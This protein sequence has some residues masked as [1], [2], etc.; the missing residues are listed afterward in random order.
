VS[1]G[2]L[3]PLLFVLLAQGVTQEKPYEERVFVERVVVNVHVVDNLGS[4]LVFRK[5]SG[6]PGR[7]SIDIRLSGHAG[8]VFHRRSYE[9]GEVP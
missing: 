6:P 4:P 1:F 3:V 8:N 2:L 7:H 5:P 9:D